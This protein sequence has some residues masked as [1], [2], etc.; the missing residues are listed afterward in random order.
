MLMPQV[1]EE[2]QRIAPT[3]FESALPLSEVAHELLQPL[4]EYDRD[5]GSEL[6]R[7]L[8]TYLSCDRD[9]VA[10]CEQLFIH[11]NTLR[12]RLKHITTRLGVDIDSTSAI[13]SLWLAC[14]SLARE[15]QMQ[16]GAPA[17][18][19]STLT[20]REESHDGD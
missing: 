7:T 12:Y 17:H 13:T 11:R 18:A 3:A 8:R 1:S 10:T 20:S 9:T 6:V 15:E 2:R 19:G 5:H 4:M 14:L 16:D